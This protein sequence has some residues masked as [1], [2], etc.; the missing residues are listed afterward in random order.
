MSDFGTRPGLEIARVAPQS[1]WTPVANMRGVV[2]EAG[3]S[4]EGIAGMNPVADGAR[5][6][7]CIVLVKTGPPP[8]WEPQ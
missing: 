8:F 6:L 2:R 1:A 4:P 3:A 5:H 7:H